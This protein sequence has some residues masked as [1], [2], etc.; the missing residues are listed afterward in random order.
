MLC[1]F[2]S[3]VPCLSFG[4]D[5]VGRLSKEGL[6]LLVLLAQNI[7]ANGRRSE[8]RALLT[9]CF[10]ILSLLCIQFL[11]AYR[12]ARMLSKEHYLALKGVSSCAEYG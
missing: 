8:L 1:L 12:P 9:R 3:D 4:D 10:P 11:A 6:S 5:S 2:T 7:W